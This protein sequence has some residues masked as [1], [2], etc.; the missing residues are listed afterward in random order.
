M[1]QLSDTEIVDRYRRDGYAVVADV[2]DDAD[3]DPMRDFI[4]AAV[5][6]HAS[7]QHARGDLASLYDDEPFERR[8]AAICEEQGVSPRD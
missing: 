8:Y 4:A 5:D 2:V 6:Q 1:A 7:Q 3:L